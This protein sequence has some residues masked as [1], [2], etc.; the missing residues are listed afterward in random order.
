MGAL[1]TSVAIHAEQIKWISYQ[2]ITNFLLLV[3]KDFVH[4]CFVSLSKIKFVLTQKEKESIRLC[5]S[6]LFLF[7]EELVY[8]LINT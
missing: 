5:L 1:F 3:T 2:R 6:I 4:S 8:L 7:W